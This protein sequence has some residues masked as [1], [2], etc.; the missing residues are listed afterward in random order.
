MED[1]YDKEDRSIMKH[2]VWSF[3]PTG[4]CPFVMAICVALSFTPRD[5]H[6]N[7]DLSAAVSEML[8]HWCF[9]STNGDTCRWDFSLYYV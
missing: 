7:P 5:D 4:L 3:D 2:Q 1:E 9:T 8:K 6:C